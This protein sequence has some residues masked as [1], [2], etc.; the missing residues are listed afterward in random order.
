MI[1]DKFNLGNFVNLMKNANKI[2]DKMKEAQE[3]LAKMEIIGESGAGVVRITMNADNYAKQVTIDPDILKE[4]KTILEE[5]IAAAINDAAQKIQ[6]AKEN[7]IQSG[8]LLGDI[9]GKKN[10]E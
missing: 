7:L 3:K 9:L 2:Q 1:G 8:D 4:D 6:K 5:L 10:E